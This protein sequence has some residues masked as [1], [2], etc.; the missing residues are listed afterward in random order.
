MGLFYNAPEP[1]WGKGSMGWAGGYEKERK[2]RGGKVV[3]ALFQI[4]GSAPE[5]D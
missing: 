5:A 1:T 3:P 4:T 2:R